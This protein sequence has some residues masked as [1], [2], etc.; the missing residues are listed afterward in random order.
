MKP[1]YDIEGTV[2]T[3]VFVNNTRSICLVCAFANLPIKLAGVFNSFSLF[4]SSTARTAGSC[5]D[6]KIILAKKE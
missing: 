6:G 5:P 1:A 3:V 2:V 4:S